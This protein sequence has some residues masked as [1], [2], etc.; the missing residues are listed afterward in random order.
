MSLEKK[1]SAIKLITLEKGDLT[2]RKIGEKKTGEMRLAETETTLKNGNCVGGGRWEASSWKDAILIRPFVIGKKR[3]GGE[4]SRGFLSEGGTDCQ[5]DPTKNRAIQDSRKRV[6]KDR[7]P[8]K[9]TLTSGQMRQVLGRHLV[10]GKTA[11]SIW[12]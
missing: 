10:F 3:R 4:R 8:R 2:R 12:G 1:R 7:I 5:N 11:S 9:R 6:K